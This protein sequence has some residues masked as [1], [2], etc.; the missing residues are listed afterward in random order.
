[1]LH[2]LLGAARGGEGAGH[3]PHH[4]T[5][6][7][8]GGKCCAVQG[9]RGPVAGTVSLWPSLAPNLLARAVIVTVVI[10]GPRSQ[11]VSD[12]QTL[13]IGADNWRVARVG[14]N[15]AGSCDTPWA[16]GAWLNFRPLNM[17]NKWAHTS[18]LN[19]VCNGP[20]CER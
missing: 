8:V 5:P 18:V 2:L 9:L 3:A 11:G 6:A 1:M 13:M 10:T 19:L 12:S 20:S 15:Y 14:A 4:L 7:Q 16:S 17:T